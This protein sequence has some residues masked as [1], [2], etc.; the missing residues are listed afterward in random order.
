MTRAK[1]KKTK[2]RPLIV[3]GTLALDL[4]KENV[5]KSEIKSRVISLPIHVAALINTKYI[6]KSLKSMNLE[7]VDIILIP[8]MAF[9]DSSVI[10]AA[11][12]LPAFKG[13][14]FAADLPIILNNLAEVTLS[15]TIPACELM[16][17][18]LRKSILSELSIVEKRERE[19][20]KKGK[21]ILVGKRSKKVWIGRGLGPR[22]LAEIVD[23][24]KL[25]D[26]KIGDLSRYYVDYGADI[27]DV[28]MLSEKSEPEE[29]R[30]IL[31]AVRK[32]VDNPISID[33]SDVDEIKV[34]FEEEVDLVLSINAQNMEE[35]SKF[36]RDTPVVVTPVNMHGM[37]PN[38]VSERVDQLERN[39]RAAN[40]LG[41][42]K[43]IADP[44]LNPPFSPS[45]TNSI[46][47]YIEFARRDPS[48]PILFGLGN[49][50][51]LLDCDSIGVNLL[52]T[53]FGLE[54][55]IGLILVTEASHK[56]RGCVKEIS[57]AVDMAVLAKNRKGP[58]KDLG[59]NLLRLKE[60]RRLEEI[61]NDE[62]ES[63]VEII[64]TRTRAKTT[65]DRKGHFKIMIDR[66][67]KKIVVIHYRFRDHK[68][69][70]MFK[71]TDPQSIYESILERGLISEMEHACYLGIEL[72]K[73]KE[74]LSTDKSYVQDRPLFNKSI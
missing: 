3:T 56:T 49:V 28:G 27:I 6:A 53:S 42:K 12:G 24:P 60:K 2:L 5:M 71:G 10:T 61:Y 70:I 40:S 9:G 59:L 7:G 14:K 68:P 44:I 32:A 62:V 8:G 41:F 16:Q 37:C 4:V 43:I 46:S 30:R 51:E 39:L 19:K 17:E 23:A 1:T 18:R 11:T 58:P 34:A 21:A 33:T 72:S 31:S 73:A 38:D 67:G 15:T 47:G 50:T 64:R 65:Y 26:N 69:D 48:I 55:G 54:L 22:I 74:A 13:P 63:K 20:I 45:L 52:L 29:I 66:K 25:A 57:T 35:V 36:A